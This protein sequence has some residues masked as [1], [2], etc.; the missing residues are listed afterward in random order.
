MRMHKTTTGEVPRELSS[1]MRNCLDLC[2]AEYRS[3]AH[4]CCSALQRGPEK[5][6]GNGER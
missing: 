4:H 3:Y 2:F 6:I 5:T 1:Y